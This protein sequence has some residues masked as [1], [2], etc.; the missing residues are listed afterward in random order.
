M[1]I[2]F[3][4]CVDGVSNSSLCMHDVCALQIFEQTCPYAK[5]LPFHYLDDFV[6]P[7]GWTHAG[8]QR[9][10]V[11]PSPCARAVFLQRGLPS[12]CV[13]ATTDFVFLWPNTF[14]P[15]VIL[16]DNASIYVRLCCV[17]ATMKD[18][19]NF[20]SLSGR[21]HSG[22]QQFFVKPS[23]IFVLCFGNKD[24]LFSQVDW[25]WYVH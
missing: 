6:S 12:R 7:S 1:A 17:F 23:S 24:H 18:P 22:L 5:E 11:K 13:F 20:V 3:S 16:C 10:F 14:W 25:N 21:T 9:F 19:T 8:F 2:S 15:P 4:R